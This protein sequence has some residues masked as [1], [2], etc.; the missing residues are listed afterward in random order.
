MMEIRSSHDFLYEIEE[1]TSE[2]TASLLDSEGP[3]EDWVSLKEAFDVDEL[4]RKARL[5][6][7]WRFSLKARRAIEALWEQRHLNRELEFFPEK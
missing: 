4:T 6:V 5:M 2:L 1:D 7:P 3:E